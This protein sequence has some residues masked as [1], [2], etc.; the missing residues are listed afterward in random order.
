MKILYASNGGSFNRFTHY[1]LKLLNRVRMKHYG[2][3]WAEYDRLWNDIH[4][5]E[6]FDFSRSSPTL[7]HA[8]ESGMF[9]NTEFSY[10]KVIELPEN[11]T[12]YMIVEDCCED[13]TMYEK[14][15][16]VIN[17]KI[18]YKT[19]NSKAFEIEHGGY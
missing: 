1:Q 4:E 2:M 13:C 10:I 11:V 18:E 17:G 5:T 16:C 19:Y 3:S 8:V 14:V 6:E 7:I 15:M 9:K 12:D